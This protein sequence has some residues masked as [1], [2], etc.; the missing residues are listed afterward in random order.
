M[1]FD[2]LTG[3]RSRFFKKEFPGSCNL[4]KTTKNNRKIA[5]NAAV[6]V[7]PWSPGVWQEIRQRE[8]WLIWGRWVVALGKKSKK[9]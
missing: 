8:F 3:R 1:R 9:M 5:E 6:Y 4:P 7:M 2:K